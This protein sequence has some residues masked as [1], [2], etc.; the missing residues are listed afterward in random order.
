MEQ[1]DINKA[2]FEIE[3]KYLIEYPDIKKIK[4]MENYHVI[5]IDQTYLEKDDKFAGGRIRRIQTN[6]KIF[7][8]YTYKERLSAMKRL[9]FEREISQNEYADLMSRKRSDSI[10]I[11]KDRHVFNY[12]GLTY[13]LDIYPFWND[14]ATIEA[15]VENEDVNIPVPPCVKLI[16]DVTDDRRY[17]NNSL[18]VNRGKIE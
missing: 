18:S 6:S 9:E 17:S 1:F 10:T 8:T 5:H 15:E 7:Y 16:K 2:P 4:A 14:K 11:E 12:S 13:E 3:C